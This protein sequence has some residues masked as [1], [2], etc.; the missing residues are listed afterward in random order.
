ME[1]EHPSCE[2]CGSTDHSQ[3]MTVRDKRHNCPGEFGLVE[4]NV[5][6][7][8]FLSPRPTRDSIAVAYPADYA[9]HRRQDSSARWRAPF[10]WAWDRYQR[11]FLGESYPVFYYRQH[12][13]E[14][15][16]EGRQPRVLDVGCGSGSKLLY[17]KRAGWETYG[18]DFSQ[19]AIDLALNNGVDFGNAGDGGSL[20]HP[21]N[22]FDAIM[23]WHSLEHHFHPKESLQEMNRVLT[24][25]GY[26]IVAVPTADNLGFRL[27]KENWGPLEPPRHLYHFTEETLGR[28]VQDAGLEVVSFHYDYTYYGLFLDE[29]ILESLENVAADRGVNFRFPRPPGYSI[30][31]RIPLLP[32]STMLGKLCKGMNLIVHFRKRA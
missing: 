32:F 18:L 12:I 23:S 4:C 29:E 24:P 21:D 5:C 7:L 2:L 19:E 31:A 3:I 30:A 14:F 15:G 6:S 1:L 8:R 11:L 26:G 27:F 20:P 13:N 28:M 22:F 9:A 25:G 10:S 17:L 16:A